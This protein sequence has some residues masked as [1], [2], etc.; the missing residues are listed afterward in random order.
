M[1]LVLVVVRSD[2]SLSTKGSYV[3]QLIKSSS[4]ST[5]FYVFG[6]QKG[7]FREKLSFNQIEL[8]T[9]ISGILSYYFL[10]FLK[11]PEDWRDGALRRLLHRKSKHG[12]IIEG[13]LSTLSET[14]NQYF[15]RS[16][17]TARLMP[18]LRKSKSRK[19]FLIDEFTS[20][21]LVDLKQLKK[22]GPIIYVS[23]DFACNHYNFAAH[24]FAK[25]LM[26]KLERDAVIQAD[27][28]IAC[29]EM[30][31]LRYVEMGAKKAVFYPNIYPIA[32]FEPYEK[33]QSPTIGIVLPK[34]WRQKGERSLREVFKALSCVNKQIRVY[35][36]GLKPQEVPRNVDLH[37][38]ERITERLD[39]LNLLSKSWIGINI[40]I[41]K[42]GANQ[43]KYDYALAGLF[44]LSD[45]LGARGD[46]LP[47]E[48]TYID[49][50]DLAAKLRQ[51]LE[52]GKEQIEAM[53]SE[54]RK[55][56]LSLAEKQRLELLKAIKGVISSH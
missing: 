7:Q 1:T 28:V 15:A 56:V 54:N 40:G 14:L 46:L 39:Y 17:R 29:S 4:N 34:Y 23:Q 3:V 47:R 33:S 51:L 9:S 21:N 24:F 53:G 2:L 20:L 18:F 35:M 16:G 27:V 30:E 38:Y 19:A 55:T 37:Y 49:S 42:G 5:S 13:F 8:A 11:S 36:I 43:K 12:L 26:Y 31:R 25:R 10:R 45:T 44:V 41:H 52:F 32:E 48:N 6:S 50:Y 22:M